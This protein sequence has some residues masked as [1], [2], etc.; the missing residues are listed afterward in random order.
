M[1]PTES[2]ERANDPEAIFR[3]YSLMVE[4]ADRVS[5]RRQSANSFFLSINTALAGGASYLGIKD[6]N[7][8]VWALGVVG[9]A[10]C[11][12]W[13]RSIVSYKT[14]NEAK[15]EVIHQLE[16]LLPTQPY[17]DEWK[18]IDPDSGKGR[19]KPFHV[20]EMAVPLIFILVHAVQIAYTFPWQMFPALWRAFG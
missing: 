5:Q 14:L 19:H 13:R 17:T 9:I 10:I 8:P 2:S 16:K 1:T 12:L 11:L 7:G 18:I 3:F 4:M 15:F 20:T 6:T